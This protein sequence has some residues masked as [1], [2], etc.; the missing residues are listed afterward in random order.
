MRVVDVLPL[1]KGVFRDSLSYFTGDSAIRAGS[2]VSVPVRGKKIL[3]LVASVRDAREI[4]TDLR[5]RNYALRK[6]ESLKSSPFLLPEFLKAAEDTAIFFVGSTGSVLSAFIP[7]PILESKRTLAHTESASS[8]GSLGKKVR[9]TLALQASDEERFSEYKSLIRERFARGL[10]VFLC[11]PTTQ[12]ADELL[13][14]LDRGIKQYS[15]VL[16]SALPKA[17][18]I[19]TWNAAL[20]EPHPVLIIGTGTFLS[21]PRADIGTIIIERESSRFYKSGVRP[22]ADVRVFAEY[23]AK[24]RGL[25]LLFGDIV[26]RVETIYKVEQGEYAAFGGVLKFRSLSGA[27]YRI[28]DMRAGVSSDKDKKIKNKFQIL[29]DDIRTIITEGS[30]ANEKLFIFTS[31]R[32]LSPV[33]LC[34][35]CGTIVNCLKCVAPV[36]LHRG[37]AH[38]FFLCHHCGEKRDARERCRICDS[39]KLETLGIGIE[40]VEEAVKKLVPGLPVFRL[41]KDVAKTNKKALEIAQKFTDAPGGILIGT[42]LATYYLKG[43]IENSAVV[44]IDS[45]F[46]LP[47]FRIDERIFYLLLSIRA[48]TTKRFLIQT[49][50]IEATLLAHAAL[51]AINDFYREEIEVR[52]KFS[53]PPFSTLIKISTEGRREVIEKETATLEKFFEGYNISIFPAF[54]STVKGKYILNILISTLR[55]SWPDFELIRKLKSL[56]PAYKI[57][58]DPESIL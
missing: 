26:L 45:L 30:K 14:S 10:S 3:S 47:D 20:S 1:S 4:K 49:R 23:F 21:I 25:E 44:S 7:K 33:T 35:D 55:S 13:T 42:E 24:A 46:S 57:Q 54:I 29:G 56:P 16:H 22:Y 39:W 52:E 6:V 50:N 38:T 11:F 9:E 51:G 34:G 8:D 17:K 28:V 40:A 31:R 37:G 15:F 58:V 32:G 19:S 41:D 18:I 43:P 5:R 12:E 53:Y 27:L 36:T 48:K 2:I